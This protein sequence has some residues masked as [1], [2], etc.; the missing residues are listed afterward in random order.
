MTDEVVTS[1]PTAEFLTRLGEEVRRR[2]KDAGLTVQQLADATRLSRRMLT[3]VEQGRANPSLVTVDKIARAFGTDFASLTRD[4][5]PDPIV[6]N[7]PGTAAGVWSSTTGSRAALQVATWHHPAAELWEWTLQPGDRY[8]AQPDPAGSEELFYVF[9]G[10]LTLE[11]EG[12]RPVSV[13]AGG[14]ARLSSDRRY[15]YVNSG[16]KP[17]RFVRVVRLA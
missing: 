5:H 6:V 15:A 4:S 3:L 14:S 13:R 2:R 12:R 11:V 8:D 1:G 10:I 9:D 17:A 16:P 7:A